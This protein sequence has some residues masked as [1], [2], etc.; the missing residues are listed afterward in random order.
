MAESQ[1]SSDLAAA[2]PAVQVESACE[3]PL[4]ST[5][6][7]NLGP[8]LLRESQDGDVKSVPAAGHD[9]ALPAGAGRYQVLEEIAQGGMGAIYKVRDPDLGRTLAL[10]VLR[11][12]HRDRLD[13]QRRFLEEAQIGGQLQHPG[14]VPVHELGHLPDRRP[15]FTMKLV[16]GR[17]LADLLRE[18]P[19][20]GA[21]LPR[22]LTIFEQVC[23]TL[24]YTHSRGVIHRDLKPSNIMVGSFGEVQVMDWGLAKL[25]G[26]APQAPPTEG[27]VG[28]STVYSSRA[29][30]CDSSATRAGTILGTPAYMPPEQARGQVD[31]LD[32]RC[33]V[34]G[35]GAI[36]CEILTGEPPYRGTQ[37]QVIAQ[38]TQ[39]DLAEASGRL[40]RCGAEPE[41]VNLALQCLSFKPLDR[42]A[43]G[44]AVAEA[45]TAY[46]AGVEQRV[47]H[48][49]LTSATA[50]ARATEERK[51]RKLTLALAGSLVLL[52][53]LGSGA[54]LWVNQYQEALEH[55]ALLERADKEQQDRADRAQRQR[56]SLARVLTMLARAEEQR[57]K[58]RES[59][60]SARW[61]EAR[62]LAE[63]AEILLPGVMDNELIERVRRLR[64]EV[65]DEEKDRQLAARLQQLWQ[66]RIYPEYPRLFADHGLSVQAMT[67]AEAAG[68]VRR[69]PA[70]TRQ[71]LIAGLDAWMVLAR[72]S[73]PERDW[74]FAVLQAADDNVQRKALR[75]A[76]VTNDLAAVERLATPEAIQRQ[77]PET[78]LLLA[79]YLWSRSLGRAIE[80]LRLAQTRFPGD[81]WITYTL[82]AALDQKCVFELADADRYE[83][84]VRYYSAALALWPDS[85][86]VLV[87]TGHALAS[88]GRFEEALTTLQRAIALQPEE[89]G[90][91]VSYGWALEQQGRSREA[92]EALRTALR[93]K[94]R[95]SHA[96]NVLALILWSQ[97]RYDEAAA[98]SR[99]AG[100][101]QHSAENFL[102]LSG[103][104]WRKGRQEEAASE[105]RKAVK[106]QT[107]FAAA[108]V[109]LQLDRL[110]IEGRFKD[111]ETFCRTI[112]ALQPKNPYGQM[113]LYM[114]LINQGRFAEALP[115]ARRCAEL[116][117]TTPNLRHIPSRAV[118]ETEQ[119]LE[120]ERQLP[121]FLRGQLKPRD[122]TERDLLW[123]LCWAKKR[124]AGAAQLYAA[125]FADDATLA[126]DLGGQHRCDA[127]RS[128]ARAAAGL[129]DGADLDAK[130]RTHWRKQALDWLGADLSA[131]KRQL[132]AELPEER[133]DAVERLRWWQQDPA[134]ASVRDAAALQQM[135]TGERAAWQE[136]WT[137][138]A[139]ILK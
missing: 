14:L 8:L 57:G 124:Y 13:L 7:V 92:E 114:T 17:T 11:D 48:A 28:A 39:G 27:A 66:E 86:E 60:D 50:R 24:G 89:P 90:A 135:S 67:Q 138:V 21:D 123:F 1:R 112:I 56:E 105:L 125:A 119:V 10:K 110:I 137:K 73:A 83:D 26:Q 51:R 131:R 130:E 126:E 37:E 113:A 23:Q 106:L 18:R 9:A 98:A 61:A 133:D 33:D 71:R 58:A 122:A 36:L 134:L 6:T 47:R 96:E 115:V 103:I 40:E 68:W 132:Q 128:A 59:N 121:A 15:F 54:V 93:L 76:V 102:G 129:G 63:Q 100:R 87:R 79:N 118:R 136:L 3:P 22:F 127:A 45:L 80:V 74:L 49:E 101:I 25:L 2:R 31:H 42:L 34:F 46:R 52:V 43:H 111:A 84:V 72:P 5:P 20:A 97:G 4:P 99:R 12:C 85:F 70:D 41:L 95:Y 116:G 16:K 109:L 32:E 55:K 64:H 19:S 88:R 75:A 38:A 77:G 94:P 69:R 108:K 62:T 81:F 104:L 120:L 117:A 29:S 53:V 35:L 78:V 91:H 30:S 82:A 139:E 65:Q 107:D 44:G